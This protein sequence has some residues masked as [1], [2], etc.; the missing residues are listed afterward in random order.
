MTSHYPREKRSRFFSLA[1]QAL[2]L[3]LIFN[4]HIRAI[5][6]RKDLYVCF[7]IILFI[8]AN[9]STSSP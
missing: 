5:K 8:C 3:T 9:P 6:V 7:V 4:Q 2:S 1:R